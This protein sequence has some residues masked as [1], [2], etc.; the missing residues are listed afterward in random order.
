MLSFSDWQEKADQVHIPQQA[1]I[2][3]KHCNSTSGDTF[4]CISPIDGRVLAKVASCGP[5]DA[6]LAVSNAR[7]A[8]NKGTWSELAPAERKKILLQFASLV[9]V[10][11]EELALLETLDMGKPI[12]LE[13]SPRSSN[14]QL[15]YSETLGE[16]TLNRDTPR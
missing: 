1:I 5:E 9:A 14:G 6:E 10:H 3:G 11:K 12:Y 15:R 8:F 2:D 7:A 4:D 13:I 16:I